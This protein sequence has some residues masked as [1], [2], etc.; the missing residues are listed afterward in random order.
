VQT[1]PASTTFLGR[2][3]GFEEG[4]FSGIEIAMGE[5]TRVWFAL[6]AAKRPAELIAERPSTDLD[7]TDVETY[8]TKKEGAACNHAGQRV[9]R[10][11]PAVWAEARSSVATR[12]FSTRRRRSKMRSSERLQS[13]CGLDTGPQG[14]AHKKR[15]RPELIAVPARVLHHAHRRVLQVAPEH[16]RGVFA[17][18]WATL[19]EMASFAGP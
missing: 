4:V 7:P 13:L 2:A 1:I 18:A 5:M 3:K 19:G 17:D 11:H 12:A 14:R 10:P 6:L 8:G 15:L 9:G 16:R